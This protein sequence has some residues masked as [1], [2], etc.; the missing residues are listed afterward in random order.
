M[1]VPKLKQDNDV[2]KDGKSDVPVLRASSH[3]KWQCAVHVMQNIQIGQDHASQSTSQA[4]AHGQS[5]H[6]A[7]GQIAKEEPRR[8]K[9]VLD[10]SIDVRKSEAKHVA[11]AASVDPW[12][13]LAL[14]FDS[15]GGDAR[16]VGQVN[17]SAK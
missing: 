14:Q 1:M 16:Q 5:F 11:G 3:R 2:P 15:R 12:L 10:D 13:C 9:M 4:R 7:H 17:T 8:C 6:L